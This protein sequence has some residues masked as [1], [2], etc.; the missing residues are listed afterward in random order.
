MTSFKWI[1]F[2]TFIF[3]LSGCG[4]SVSKSSCLIFCSSTSSQQTNLVATPTPVPTPT[5]PPINSLY[6]IT[7]TETYTDGA[8]A[9]SRY[10]VPFG[11]VKDSYGN[12]YVSDSQNS[13]IRKIDTSGNVTV[14]AG[15]PGLQGSADGPVGTG[16][17]CRPQGLAIDAQNNLFIAEFCNTLVRKVDP[18][19][20]ITTVAGH[21]G[22]FAIVDGPVANATFAQLSW[23]AVDATGNVFVTDSTSIREISTAGQVT[24]FVGMGFTGGH[25][26]GNGTNA[27]LYGV[28]GLAFD[29][30]GNL[31]FND[32]YYVR[33][34][35]PNGD[36]TTI[37]GGFNTYQ[38]GTG[39]NAGFGELN[40]ITID[41]SGNLFVVDT[42]YNVVREVTQAGVTT[43]LAGSP[44]VTGDLDGIG[45]AATFNSINGIAFDQNGNLLVVDN[46]SNTIRKVTLAGTVSTIAGAPYSPPTSPRNSAGPQISGVAV[47]SAGNYFYSTYDKIMKTTPSGVVSVF[48]GTAANAYNDGVGVAAGFSGPAGIVIDGNDNLFVADYGNNVIRKITSAGVVTTFAG[49]FTAQAN[50]VDGVGS[51]AR[52]ANP[53]QMAMDLNQNLYVE[54]DTSYVIR[55]ITPNGTVST[56]AG[57]PGNYGYQDGQG[58]AAQFGEMEGMTTDAAGNLYVCDPDNNVIRE[59]TPSGLVSTFAGDGN[60]GD[61]DGTLL[62]AEFDTPKS[63]SIDSGGNFIISEESGYFRKISP[64]GDVTTISGTAGGGDASVDGYNPIGKANSPTYSTLD[65]NGNLIFADEHLYSLRGFTSLTNPPLIL[66]RTPPAPY[67][68]AT[69]IPPA[70]HNNTSLLTTLRGQTTYEPGVGI[71]ATLHSPSSTVVDSQGNIFFSDTLNHVIRK[72]ATDGTVSL[73]AGRPGI[74]GYADGNGDSALFNS[75]LGIVIGDKGNILVADSQNNVVREIFPDGDVTTYLGI[76]GT[77][78]D[79]NGHLTSHDSTFGNPISLAYDSLGELF[80]LDAYNLDV[81]FINVSS[82]GAIQTY[83]GGFHAI[84]L[85]NGGGGPPPLTLHGP[86]S[87]AL[88]SQDNIFIADET[89]Q[90]IYAMDLNGTLSVYA[91]GAQIPGYF[92]AQGTG[93]RFN[94]PYG[95]VIDAHENMYVS[96]AGNNL[97]RVIDVNQNVSTLAGI[98]STIGEIDGAGGSA[99]FNSPLGMSMDANSNLIVA[100]SLNNRIRLVSTTTAVVSTLVGAALA[101]PTLSPVNGMAMDSQGNTFFTRGNILKK[102]TPLGVAT[103]FAGGNSSGKAD[104][105]GTAASF[106]APMGVAIDGNDTIYLADSGNNTIRKIDSSANVTTLAGNAKNASAVDVNATGTKARFITPTGITVDPAGTIYVTEPTNFTIRA[107]S[108]T[109]VVTTLAGSATSGYVDATGVAASF[110]SPNALTTDS[111]GNLFVVDAANN[112]IRKVTPTGVVTTFA[113]TFGSNASTDGQGT[114]ASFSSPVGIVRDGAGNLY[115][116]EATGA[117]RKITSGGLVSTVYTNSVLTHTSIDGDD[118]IGNSGAPSWLE[119]DSSGNIIFA[120]TNLNSIR[121]LTL[122]T[123]PPLVLPRP[124]PAPFVTPTPLPPTPTP[125]PYTSVSTSAGYT[126]YVDGPS[127]SARFN[128]PT[129]TAYDANGNLFIADAANHVIRKMDTSGNV[130]L[131]AGSPGNFGSND[132][133]GSLAQFN[134]PFALVFDSL[135]NLFVTDTNNSLIRKITPAGLVS[136]FVGNGAFST[137]RG[138]TIDGH[139]TLYVTDEFLNQIF[140]VDNTGAVSTLAGNGTAG[141]V[142]AA[143][144]S[145]EFQNPTGIFFSFLNATLYVADWTNSAL[146]T[147]ANGNVSTLAAINGNSVVVDSSGNSYLAFP[148]GDQVYKYSSA[149]VQ[150]TLGGTNRAPGF[151]DGTAAHSLFSNPMGISLDP[152]SN[153]IVSDT[154]NNSIRK[155]VVKTTSTLVGKAQIIPLAAAGYEAN[156]TGDQAALG[157]VNGVVVDS[158]GNTFAT[159]SSNT[160]RKIAVTTNVVTTFSGTAGTTGSAVGNQAHSTYSTPTGIAIDSSNNLYVS[161]SMNSTIRKITSAGVSSLFAGKVGVTGH[162]NGAAL[163]HATFK[164]PMGLV[165]DPAGDLFVVDMADNAVREISA[166]G[167]VTLVAGG[168]NAGHADGTGAAASFNGPTA[169]TIDANGNL[170]VCDTGNFSIREITPAG[171]VSTYAGKRSPADG[172]DG[173]NYS[174]FIPI[175]IT[176]DALGSLDVATLGITEGSYISNAQTYS[177]YGLGGIQNIDTTGYLTNVIGAP[178]RPVGVASVYKVQGSFTEDS[179]YMGPSSTDGPAGQATVQPTSLAMDRNGNVV[180]GN[181]IFLAVPMQN[182]IAPTGTLSS[183]TPPVSGTPIFSSYGSVRLLSK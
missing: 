130:T 76:A 121:Q 5:P 17:L 70:V 150:T 67:T 156:G 82:N 7:G 145:A 40:G 140:A 53:F 182:Q 104:G 34:A 178:V 68:E 54:E 183:F 147:L 18:S 124:S 96:E 85:P 154:N 11:I 100:D 110:A 161:D 97:I 170:F 15:T 120:D 146:R 77:N 60:N 49:S 177:I 43:T 4:Y 50:G 143:Y 57:T 151:V 10:N 6:T 152:S 12:M 2:L 119:L 31:F 107:V 111:V 134:S 172:V 135:G 87:I 125:I 20:N 128:Q 113:G 105:N 90:V 181:S 155:I 106:N 22:T 127:A 71:A 171:V 27:R 112:V 101:T 59:I 69:P 75:P 157:A 9:S 63:I 64:A 133:L 109:G 84:G 33:K 45:S 14:F 26:D 137:P 93:A 142:D 79:H 116:T 74:A 136:T 115:V 24:T 35:T 163:N 3:A 65:S 44:S 86:T 25:T 103:N 176:I 153:V 141:D 117:V 42:E 23:I 81:R 88:D 180:I 41:S 114:S 99:T 139:D 168:G 28:T 94:Q 48:A 38:D 66:P 123:M 61:L 164:Q 83:P 21:N 19:G 179:V 102:L 30:S 131:F 13:A 72:I 126:G 92:D 158:L 89:D 173:Y 46:V 78:G 16:Q 166:A 39:A 56:F 144:G 138:I 37:A 118:T 175:G 80:I 148:G 52:F 29:A 162:V 165:F 8:L 160:I 174:S 98:P 91:G 169:I 51:H 167:T 32:A 108:Q 47:D 122:L 129:G 1:P 159:T 36:V 95:L 55:K 62:T 73:V 132:G 149:N 58:A